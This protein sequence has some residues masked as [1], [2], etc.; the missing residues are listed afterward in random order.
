MQVEMED[1]E[2][3]SS[4]GNVGDSTIDNT[5]QESNIFDG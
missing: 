1:F 2:E 3:G 4:E 5:L